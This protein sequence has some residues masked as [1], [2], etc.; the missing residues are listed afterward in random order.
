MLSSLARTILNDQKLF[1][2][3]SIAIRSKVLKYIQ[4]ENSAMFS[5]KMLNV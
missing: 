4:Q 3:V 5:K 1:F 2:A